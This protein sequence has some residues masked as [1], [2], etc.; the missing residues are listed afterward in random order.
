MF[1]GWVQQQQSLQDLLTNAQPPQHLEG[2]FTAPAPGL[3]YDPTALRAETTPPEPDIPLRQDVRDI[4]IPA[5]RTIF[6]DPTL[7]PRVLRGPLLVSDEEYLRQA[8]PEALEHARRMASLTTRGA[9]PTD[10][11]IANSLRD[12]AIGTAYAGTHT[13]TPIP[14]GVSSLP[15]RVNPMLAARVGAGAAGLAVSEET[16]PEEERANLLARASRDLT[17]SL[18]GAAAPSVATTVARGVARQA[19]GLA[20]SL[21]DLTQ[22][23]QT[24]GA[25]QQPLPNMPAAGQTPA[26]VISALGKQNL[27]LGFK[28]Q[29][30]NIASQMAELARAPAG[31]VM[32][33]QGDQALIGVRAGVGAV[34]EAVRQFAQT[35]SSGGGR[36]TPA[37]LPVFRFIGA[38]DDFYRVLGSAQGAAMEAQRLVNASGARSAQDV[39]QVLQQNEQQLHQAG[40]QGGA[41]SVFQTIGAQGAQDVSTGFSRWKE[42]LLGATAASPVW[43]D[44]L[45]A[46][47]K[48]GLGLLVDALVPFAGMPARLFDIGIGRLPVVGEARRLGELGIALKRGDSAAA[49]RAFGELGL[50]SMLST[51]I[52]SN[53]LAGNITGPDDPDHPN[54][55]KINGSWTDYSGWGAFQLP[56][57]MPAAAVDEFRKTD[58]RLGATDREYLAAVM[59]AWA[60]TLSNAY[61]LNGLFDTISAIGEGGLAG[62]ASKTVTSY[63]DRLSPSFLAEVERS[64]DTN[65]R[66]VSKEFPQNV[67]ERWMSRVPYLAETLPAQ[68]E[69]TT[70]GPR[71]RERQGIVGTLFGVEAP[72]AQTPIAR[73]IWRLNRLGYNVQPPGDVPRQIVVHGSLVRL[74]PD[75]QRALARV[76]G[77]RLER[78]L[79]S[80]MNT[81]YW[82]TLTDDQ[83]A[84]FVARALNQATEQHVVA[85][86]RMTPVPEQRER[87]ARGQ[88]VVGRLVEQGEFGA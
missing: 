46:G 33:G 50:Q 79:S 82:A 78:V 61:Y 10:A 62:A 4:A 86:R 37:W 44:R 9:E 36:Q 38:I 51:A 65:L 12:M 87:L 35:F 7:L 58:N 39:R 15:A 77:E 45:A 11:Q 69:P 31:A 1:D 74:S 63:T 73:E 40:Q 13:G 64:I 19:R 6:E 76:R 18:L 26:Q 29:V 48:Q 70:G 81:P 67:V 14:S 21:D 71:L 88:R 28:S 41:A 55:V 56:L 17:Y 23:R 54:S 80:R 47:G 24:L 85:W 72:E 43:R 25:Q 49:Q 75:E 68:V 2:G 32:A 8:S 16:M 42:G 5:S 20:P 52:L 30:N 53:T 83:K 22:I 34:P 66:A 84:R 27:L 57:A 59:S 60:K 3:G